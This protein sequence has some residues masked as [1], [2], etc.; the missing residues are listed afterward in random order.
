MEGYNIEITELK[1]NGKSLFAK[2]YGKLDR[3]LQVEV[4]VRMERIKHGNLGV[5][6][7]LP[8]GIIEIKFASGLRVYGGWEGKSLLLL[9]IGGT[10]RNQSSDIDYSKEIWL[11]YTK[12][13]S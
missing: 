6:R 5:H 2:W 4:D 8:S 13:R 10:K 7:N 1:I 11:S 12:T 9:I 3:S